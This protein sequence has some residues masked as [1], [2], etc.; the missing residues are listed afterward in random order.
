MAPSSR[1]ESLHAC[2]DWCLSCGASRFWK[3]LGFA[4][5]DTESGLGQS[6]GPEVPGRDYPFGYMIAFLP[7]AIA[8]VL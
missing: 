2:R 8:V 3:A 7:N 6:V 4:A 5:Q 1:D